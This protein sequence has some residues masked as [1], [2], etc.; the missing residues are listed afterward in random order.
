MQWKVG[1]SCYAFWSE[2]GNVYA[3]TISSIN[4]EKGTC[5]VI[6]TDYGNEEEQN[7]K[8]LLSDLEEL[9]EEVK[10]TDVC[11]CFIS[12]LVHVGH[13]CSVLCSLFTVQISG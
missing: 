5:V 7:L 2:D 13:T 12:F 8:D 11:S 10:K 3:A 6:Y 1:D 9:D 4:P